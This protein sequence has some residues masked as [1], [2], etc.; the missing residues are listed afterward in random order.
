[1]GADRQERPPG[2]A[3]NADDYDYYLNLL[4]ASP[5]LDGFD[6]EQGRKVLDGWLRSSVVRMSAIGRAGR[7]GTQ[8]DYIQPLTIGSYRAGLP[9]TRRQR[10]VHTLTHDLLVE[11]LRLRGVEAPQSNLGELLKKAVGAGVTIGPAGK[12]VAEYDGHSDIDINAL[13]S[14]YFLEGF[15][16]LS[17]LNTPHGPHDSAVPAATAGLANDLLDYMIAYGGSLAPSAFIDRF[18]ALISLRLFQLPLWL[19]RSVRHVVRTGEKSPDMLDENSRQPAG[20]LLRLHRR[21]RIGFGRAGSAGG[22]AGPGDHAGF[23]GGP[24]SAALAAP[25]HALAAEEGRGDHQSADDRQVVAMLRERENPLV[26]AYAV[27]LMQSI[28]EE[29][30]QNPSGTDDDLDYIAAVLDSDLRPSTSSPRCCSRVWPR[31]T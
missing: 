31:R 6:D 28:E 14:L 24:D 15:T 17:A 20:A 9:K 13:L 1:M 25:G 7:A 8:M 26:E 3:K 27:V 21:A 23:H 5:R 11:R 19:A 4:A 18:A 22:A 16:P 29:T 12:Y 10:H 30:K 2:A